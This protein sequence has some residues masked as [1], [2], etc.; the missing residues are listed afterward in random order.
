MDTRRTPHDAALDD[1]PRSRDAQ[2]PAELG[3][4]RAGIADWEQYLAD[5][6]EIERTLVNDCDACG[7]IAD[8][9]VVGPHGG[10][11]AFCV[12]VAAC[13]RR[14]R[15]VAEPRPSCDPL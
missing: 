10:V 6:G 4:A 12:D 11:L 2:Y 9:H 3:A 1:A 13:E 8:V 5:G 15:G 14:R 7:V